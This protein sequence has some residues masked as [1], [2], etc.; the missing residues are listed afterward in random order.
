MRMQGKGDMKNLKRFCI[1]LGF[2]SG[3]LTLPTLAVAEDPTATLRNAELTTNP[4]APVMSGVSRNEK[5][6]VRNYPEQPPVI[7]H[8]I[9][10]YQIDRNSNKCLTCHSRKQATEAGAPMVSVTHYM[11]RGGQ[12][13]AFVTARRFFCNQCHVPQM[14]VKPLVRNT[15]ED[16]DSLIDRLAKTGRK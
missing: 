4:K 7:P 8:K 15:F 14:D 10:G 12:V 9:R 1:C 6:E 11:D 3:I 2:V 5:R 16:A 13:R